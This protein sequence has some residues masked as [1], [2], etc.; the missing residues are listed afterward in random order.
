MLHSASQGGAQP[1]ES[2]AHPR[3]AF[4]LFWAP[5]FLSVKWGW[6]EMVPELLSRSDNGILYEFQGGEQPQ[7]HLCAAGAFSCKL[8]SPYPGAE[9][10]YLDLLLW[11]KGK[12]RGE[13]EA[14]KLHSSALP[15]SSSPKTRGGA[16]EI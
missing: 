7:M 13:A 11:A 10:V 8:H 2:G 12:R 3:L 5:A 1:W 14:G 6:D 9:C 16:S 15:G 4:A